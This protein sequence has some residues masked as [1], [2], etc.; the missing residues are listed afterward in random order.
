MEY[1]AKSG[2]KNLDSQ[3]LLKCGVIFTVFI[4]R[5][6]IIAFKCFIWTKEA[7]AAI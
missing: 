5:M 3:F 6:Q 2:K 1:S 7:F 4:E